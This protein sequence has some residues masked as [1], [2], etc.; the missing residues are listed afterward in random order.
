MN[1]TGLFTVNVTDNLTLLLKAY[2]NIAG[3]I[4]GKEFMESKT[5]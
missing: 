3:N 5:N 4:A 2:K 1:V